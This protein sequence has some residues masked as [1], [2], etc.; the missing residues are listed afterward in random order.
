ME[1][2][3]L[4]NKIK[5]MEPVDTM[6]IGIWLLGTI[7]NGVVLLDANKECKTLNALDYI[8]LGMTSLL[9]WI[10]PCIL[11]IHSM[12]NQLKK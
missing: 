4:Y 3:F 12:Y 11:G 1:S 10:L 8:I 6:L 2:I 5:E 9:S 7:L